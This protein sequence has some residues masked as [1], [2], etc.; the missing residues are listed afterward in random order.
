MQRFDHP[1]TSTGNPASIYG[2]LGGL[3]PKLDTDCRRFGFDIAGKGQG[4]TDL[5]SEALQMN[6]SVPSTTRR[7]REH[8]VL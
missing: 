2:P 1:A 7:Q 8:C 3:R 4:W 6:K 5:A